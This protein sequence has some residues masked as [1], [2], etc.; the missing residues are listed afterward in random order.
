MNLTPIPREDLPHA[1][2]AM[3]SHLDPDT[4][5][6]RALDRISETLSLFDAPY[7]T[8]A[9][10]DAGVA[11]AAQ[12]GISTLDEAPSASFSWD[13]TTIRARSEAYVLIH[14][15]AHWQIAPPAR[16]GLADFGLGAGP[17]TGR[18]G[19]ADAARCVSNADKEREELLASLLGILWEAAL[20]QPA[21]HA[22]I[23]QNW[24]E[25]WDRPAAAAQF[26]RTVDGLVARGLIDG[27][28]APYAGKDATAAISSRNSGHASA[29][30]ST[31]ADAGPSLGK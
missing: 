22:F 6:V 20:G 25:A 10:R 8:A 4:V 26:A 18:V 29:E 24:L 16:R 5:P 31:M 28:G 1:L 9:H 14:E 17:E 2:D 13:G 19:D 11:L 27:S 23:E 12:L 21:I 30:T 15:I 7:D 3:R